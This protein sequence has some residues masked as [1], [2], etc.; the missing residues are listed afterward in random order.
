MSIVDI[1]KHNALLFTQKICNVA[2]DNIFPEYID[3]ADHIATEDTQD[4]IFHLNKTVSDVE[5]IIQIL[6]PHLPEQFYEEWKEE[7]YEATL[8]SAWIH[9]IGMLDDRNEHGKKSAEFI[10][11]KDSRF[12]FEKIDII[13]RIKI[14][15]LC[16]RHHR[17]WSTVVK[18]IKSLLSKDLI[19]KLNSYFVDNITPTW[20]LSLSGKLLST[21]DS[22]R[23]RGQDLRNNLGNSF[24]LCSECINCNSLYEY[25][26]NFCSV[27]NCKNS[28]L[29]TK[30]VFYHPVK[31]Y[32]LTS[33]SLKKFIIYEQL[34]DNYYQKV[35]HQK[36]IINNQNIK[37]LVR[38]DSQIFTCG[39]ILLSNVN[40]MD[41][42]S[43]KDEITINQIDTDDIEDSINEN[44]KTVYRL[45][46]DSYNPEPA[47][48][49]FSTYIVN[50]LADNLVFQNPIMHYTILY[51]EISN[52]ISFKDYLKKIESG[53]TIITTIQHS[54]KRW[55]REFNKVL[56]IEINNNSLKEIVL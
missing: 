19:S 34:E 45:T 13:D 42:A 48:F 6:K 17:E 36:Q 44:Y 16:I 39:D 3:W 22:L 50:Y 35:N 53:N 33:N 49:C 1:C 14:G 47:L 11:K 26:A 24:F 37:I 40:I 9:D 18:Y 32:Q 23:Y 43:W 52:G 29:K 12:E 8:A 28:T 25:P 2:P 10:V 31:N 51:I 5:K 21:A 55:K 7:W 20:T 30:S 41:Y 15:I 46:L 54:F 38:A 56:P 27:T 4:Y